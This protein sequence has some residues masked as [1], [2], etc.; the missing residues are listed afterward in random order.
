MVSGSV[1]GLLL[2]LF[3]VA[4]NYKIQFV[5]KVTARTTVKLWYNIHILKRE[6]HDFSAL[7]G[8]QKND[9]LYIGAIRFDEVRAIAS[10]RRTNFTKIQGVQIAHAPDDCEA[11]CHLL[12]ELSRSEDFVDYVQIRKQTRWFYEALYLSESFIKENE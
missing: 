1:T 10:C 5:D 2:L 8:P 11:V 6:A 9:I 4:N 7:L 3:N 12:R